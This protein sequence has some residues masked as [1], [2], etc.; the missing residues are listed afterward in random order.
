M[1]TGHRSL[2]G[3]QSLPVCAICLLQSRLIPLWPSPVAPQWYI[4]RLLRLLSRLLSGVGGLDGGR[5]LIVVEIP[6]AAESYRQDRCLRRKVAFGLRMIR[7]LVLIFE[8]AHRTGPA[9]GAT[10]TA[11]PVT[12]HR[13]GQAMR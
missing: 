5:N 3:N 1:P 7:N 2:G 13:R 9:A 8:D 4:G 12:Q 10:M 6:Q 11:I